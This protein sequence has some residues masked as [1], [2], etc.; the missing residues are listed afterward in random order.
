MN[1]SFLTTDEPLFLPKFFERLLP[2]LSLRH[3][4]RVY[5]VPPL[6]KSQTSAQAARRYLASFGV[7][8]TIQLTTRLVRAKLAGKS[9]ES[10]CRRTGVAYELIA[11]VNAPAFLDRLR[12]E[13]AELLVSVSCPQIFRRALIDLPPEGILNIHGAILPQ[14]RGVLPSF[15]M[16]ANGEQEA[17]VSIYFVNEAIDAGEL[18]GQEVFSIRADESLEEFILRSKLIAADLLSR[19]IKAMER[20]NIERRPMDLAQGSYYPWPDA[21]A[22]QRF[23]AA[24]RRLW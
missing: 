4:L 19:T 16:M 3:T 5:S 17:G 18:C 7:S 12:R 9:I 23:R 20:G 24:G 10:V 15:W 8:A 6:Y 11:D 22:I 14:Y 2:A 21:Q 1:I 13:N